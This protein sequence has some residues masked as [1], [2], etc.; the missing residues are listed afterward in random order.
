MIKI[1]SICPFIPFVQGIIINYY[2]ILQSLYPIQ[3][4]YFTKIKK[5][6]VQYWWKN[7]SSRQLYESPSITHSLLWRFHYQG[8]VELND[9]IQSLN[10]TL[11]TSRML[12]NQ[13]K[14]KCKNMID[15]LSKLWCC[16][17]LNVTWS[18]ITEDEH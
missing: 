14:K 17:R 8:K 5:I 1:S 16:V 9:M 6:F 4:L 10:S 15:Q 3:L 11:E 12:K 18:S 7:K 13:S 2:L